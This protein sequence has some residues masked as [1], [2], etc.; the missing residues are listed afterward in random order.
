MLQNATLILCFCHCNGFHA[1]S[2][3]DGK[4][5]KAN[6]KIQLLVMSV[7]QAIPTPR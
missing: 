3:D 5:Q 2:T 4:F 6:F 1:S 7:G